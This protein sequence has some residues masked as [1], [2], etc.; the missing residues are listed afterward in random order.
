MKEPKTVKVKKPNS[1]PLINLLPDKAL[2]CIKQDRE[3]GDTSKIV[4][5]SN[6][7]HVK[8]TKDDPKTGAPYVALTSS[9]YEVVSWIE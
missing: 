4:Y 6:P 2:K 3:F 7:F 5:V 1:D 8:D 9:D